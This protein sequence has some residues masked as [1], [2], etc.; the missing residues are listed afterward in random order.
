[1]TALEETSKRPKPPTAA[2]AMAGGSLIRLVLLG[3]ACI[4]L[5][6]AGPSL[7]LAFGPIAHWLIM[8]ATAALAA[9][10]ALSSDRLPVRTALIVIAVVAIAM[11]IPQLL[12]TPYLSDDIYRYVWDGRVQA[13]GINPYRYLPAAPELAPLRDGAIYPLINRA[14][15]APTIYPPIAQAFFLAVTRLGETVLVMKLGLLAFEALALAATLLVVAHLGL[16]VTRIAAFAWHPLAVWEIAGS[17]HID[18]GMVGLMMLGVAAFLSRKALVGGILVAAAALMKPIALVMLPAFW[19][20]WDWRLP[21]VVITTLV[22]CY[23][24]YAAVGTRVFGYLPG[25]VQEE[26]LSHGQGFRY[27]LIVEAWTGPMAHSVAI[28]A[29]TAALMLGGLALLIGFRPKTSDEQSIAGAALLLTTFLVLLTPHYP[30]YYLALVPFL[31]VY[32]TSATLW[33]L[34]IGGVQTYEKVQGTFLA[35]Y[36]TRQIIFHSLVLVA[37]AW[38]ARHAMTK[39]F[40]PQNSRASP[41]RDNTGDV[42]Q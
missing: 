42:A 3:T 37:I 22:A 1:M 18:A 5:T 10:A 11:R 6:I 15:Y 16:P 20:P 28:Y 31:T 36:D 12:L 14:D 13:A 30:W 32:P 17:G 21:A 25:Y 41:R 27:L 26:E 7:H 8:I 38:D 24:P 39:T 23:L 4:G 2:S 33:L 35:P 29:A 19:R 40:S 34:T 9:T